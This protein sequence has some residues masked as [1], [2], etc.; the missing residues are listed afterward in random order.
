MYT[1]MQSFQAF[2]HFQ[3]IKLC[4]AVDAGGDA[5]NIV[6]IT[7]GEHK[8]FVP[9]PVKVRRVGCRRHTRMRICLCVCVCARA[10]VCIRCV[11][12]LS[13]KMEELSHLLN[14]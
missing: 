12:R 7:D 9:L 13:D 11:C 5:A 10:G 1:H 6:M 8:S 2:F 14:R 4:T 3:Y